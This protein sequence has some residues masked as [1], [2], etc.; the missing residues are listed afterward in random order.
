MEMHSYESLSQ[1]TIDELYVAIG[2]ILTERN[3]FERD[4]SYHENL[5]IMDG[6]FD[7]SLSNIFDFFKQSI[8]YIKN[9]TRD[10]NRIGHEWVDNNINLFRSA[11]CENEKIIKFS[12]S[13]DE[14]IL[15]E[16]ILGIILGKS[17]ISIDIA[18]LLTMVIVKNGIYKFCSFP[19]PLNR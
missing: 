17:D 12:E 5:N 15:F 6:L 13:E 11:I 8:N 4:N 10:L 14:A 16:I 18:S 3:T 9:K 19:A 2:H 7:D 1:L